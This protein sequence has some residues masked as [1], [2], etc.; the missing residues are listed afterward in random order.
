MAEG[1]EQRVGI[2]A[3]LEARARRIVARVGTH[4][5]ESSV[6]RGI[7]DEIALMLDQ[8]DSWRQVK[9]RLVRSLLHGE[10]YTNTELMQMEAR[11]PRYS[12]YRFPEREKLQRRLLDIERE[13]RR[14]DAEHAERMMQLHARLQELLNRHEQV[15][16][17]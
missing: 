6:L 13:R 3:G 4:R 1:L 8:I 17:I 7:V 2:A 14:H 9:E 12:P 16:S 5:I 10:M 11:T 15:M